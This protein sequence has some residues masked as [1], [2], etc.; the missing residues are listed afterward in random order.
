MAT[1]AAANL[2][3]KNMGEIPVSVANQDKQRGS[4]S[5]DMLACCYVSKEKLEMRRVPKPELTDGEDAILRVTGTTVCGSDLHLY[6]GEIMQLKEGDILGHECMGVIE[7]VGPKV[8]KFQPGDRVVAAFNIACGQCHFCKEKLFTACEAANNS[9][10]MEKLYGHRIA[11]VLGYSHFLGGFAGAQAEYARIL[12]AD[13]NLIKIPESVPDEKALFLSDI[14]PT[15]YH[16]VWRAGVQEGDVVGVWGLGPIGLCAV[17]WLRNVFK[18]KRIIAID[19]VPARLE[20]ASKRWGA[21]VIN[22]ETDKDVAAKIFD[23]CPDGLDRAIDCAGFRYA[24]NLLH[25]FERAVGLETDTS[26]VINE[27]I[28]ATKKFGTAALI[29]D[30]AAYANHVLVGG[31]MEKGISLVGCGQAPIQRH[32]ELCLKHIIDGSFDPTAVLTHRFPLEQTVQ[33]YRRFDQKEAAIMKTFIE[34]KF[35]GPVYPG[36]PMTM[37]VD[38]A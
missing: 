19:N 13:T 17:Q 12:F 21:E 25:K 32:W 2:A 38:D 33:A 11:G 34:T 5:T 15:S 29:A 4:D 30:Y 24:K 16:A 14:V 27:M 28:R 31:I 37:N 22:F 26:E 1:N 6:H 9:S 23:L 20:L 7:K 10:V 18:A 3:Q 36:T 8:T 35:S